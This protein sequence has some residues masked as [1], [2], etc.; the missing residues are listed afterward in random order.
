MNAQGW[1]EV[2][3]AAPLP[4]RWVGIDQDEVNA[5]PGQWLNLNSGTALMLAKQGDFRTGGAY[6]LF[7][8]AGPRQAAVELK[9][10]RCPAQFKPG[11][12]DP[13]QACDASYATVRRLPGFA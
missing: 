2:T 10:G 7:F 8:S 6:R 12:D 3:G 5:Q 13:Q 11:A 4:E 1:I 9:V